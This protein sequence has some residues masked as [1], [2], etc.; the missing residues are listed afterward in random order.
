[1]TDDGGGGGDGDDSDDCMHV[2]DWEQLQLSPFTMWVLEFELSLS[3][4]VASWDI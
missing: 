1:M 2:E 4:L 3:G